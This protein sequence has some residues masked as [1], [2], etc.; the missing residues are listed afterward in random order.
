MADWTAKHRPSTLAEI[1][2]N[3]SACEDLRDWAEA[4]P[5]DGRAV[6]LAGRPGV[7]KTSAAHALATEMG[8]ELIEVNASDD[9]TADAIRDRVGR[10]AQNQ[11]L[12]GGG[13]QLVVID[14]ADSFHRADS[15]GARA[16]SD[17]VSEANQPLIL[18][19]NEEY[20]M[21]D[22]IRRSVETIEFRAVS[23]RSILP[24]L[25]DI[26]REEGIEF[27][28]EALEAIA[29]QNSGDLRSAIND[30]QA[31]AENAKT[32]TIEDVVAGDRDETTDLWS[33][34]D[35]VLK[36]ADAETALRTTYDV[37]ETPDDLLLWVEDKAP[38]VYDLDELARAYEF[39][40]N[41]DRWLG[42]V[43]ATQNY[44]YWRYA[45]D[46]ISGGVAAARSTTRG[47]F[48]RY[49]G[50]PYRSSRDQTRD[51]VATQIATTGGLSVGTAR[52]EVLP[53]LSTM[54]HHCHA[55]ELTIQMAGTYDL[56][57]DEVSFVT[58]SGA[59]TNKVEG[60][61]EE[62]QERRQSAAVGRTE[63]AFEP[64]AEET[65]SDGD[66][67][68][69]EQTETETDSADSV[70]EDSGETEEEDSQADLGDFV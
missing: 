53:Y 22:S 26:C 60:I 24:A 58:G 68:A 59:S 28:S 34:L 48:T 18:I 39:L 2:G 20:E 23:A 15:G 41:A 30:L 14:E 17:I 8:W 33:Y 3:D 12:G 5:E 1:R 65:A 69:A 70:A 67:P 37:D 47:G 32:L 21:P 57:A 7:G 51:Y 11:T 62:A 25:R 16:L 27:E 56:D 52:R 63:G 61:I 13:R 19:V 49:G 46:N 36:E 50:A 29:E 40:G 9:R 6:I 35:A 64:R 44:G 55:R 4:W 45:T 66:D 31:V 10:A 54:T 43:R 38:L 42:R